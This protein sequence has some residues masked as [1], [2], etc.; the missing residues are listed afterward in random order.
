MNTKLTLNLDKDIIEKAKQYAKVNHK[1][2]S[3]LVESYFKFLFEKN[4]EDKNQYSSLVND[5]SGII[6][7]EEINEKEEYLNYLMEKHK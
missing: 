2:L 6:N 5:L 1:S 4:E 7:Y 3:Q